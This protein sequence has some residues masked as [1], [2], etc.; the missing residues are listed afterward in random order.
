MSTAANLLSTEARNETR[1]DRWTVAAIAMLAFMLTD[2][3]HEVLGHGIGYVLGGGH[4]WL[5]TT[6]R[7]VGDTRLP[8]P[9]WR[10]L[11]L[12]GPAGNL[13]FAAL[14]WLGQRLIRGS[15]PRI[16]LLCL[17]VL[18]FSLYW[19]FGYMI[20]CGVLGHGDWFALIDGAKLEW[21]W[22][23][24][25]CVVG[26]ALY[27]ATTFLVAAEFHWL[28]SANEHSSTSRVRHL[29]TVS[30]LA[31][32]VIACLGA[33]LDPHGPMEMLNSGAASSFLATL[34]L[35]RTPRFFPRAP[36]RPVNSSAP[37]NRSVAWIVVSLAIAILYIVVLGRG[38]RI[39]F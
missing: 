29:A 30:Y 22:R 24:A 9:G 1:D 27:R 32:G 10:I 6:T 15:A 13:L 31:G 7:I 18:A 23:V 39:T 8:D 20:Y 2:V 35:L 11:D 16:R 33:M 34:G 14:G 5:S 25:L 36:D 38:L 12:G 21:L 4:S 26:I 3:G 19:A 37:I 28:V 17:L